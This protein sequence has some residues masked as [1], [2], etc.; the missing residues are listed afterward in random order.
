MCESVSADFAAV[1]TVQVTCLRDA[2]FGDW[3]PN[4]YRSMDV[5][6]REDRDAAFDRC[7]AEADWTL[8]I[9]P[10]L[11]GALAERCRRVIERGGR[12]LGGS[13][14][15]I[16]LASDK[17]ATAEHLARSGVP[18]PHGVRFSLGQPW[19]LSLRYPAVWKPL[20][21]AGSQGLWIVEHRDVPLPAPEPRPGRLEELHLRPYSSPHAPR[22][23]SRHAQRDEAI[24]ASVSFLCGPGRH[25]PLPACR[26]HLTN[27]LRYLGGS[28]PLTPALAERAT[29][30][31]TRAVATLPESLGFFGV[32][33]ILG[34]AADGQD[35]LII[36]INPRLTTSYVGLRAAC[37]QNLAAAMLATVAGQV[38]EVSFRDQAIEFLAD[39]S[40]VSPC[41]RPAGIHDAG[42]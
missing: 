37:R 15:C 41:N 29:M 7:A 34:A 21:G 32:D 4:G 35:D 1:E 39:G 42:R 36:E 16:D 25:T 6:S 30:L 27:D 12:L 17:Q 26:Q 3:A 33:L 14:A 24:P 9:A 19:P 18:V 13:L 20:D 5:G 23:E 10:E 2:R 31:A 40:L 8:V 38:C 22:E 11:G 28:L